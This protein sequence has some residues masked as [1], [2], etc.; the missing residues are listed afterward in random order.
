MF[1]TNDKTGHLATRQAEKFKV[2]HANTDRLR[3]SSLIF[4]QNMLNKNEN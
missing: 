2:Q 1:P 4:M 3:N